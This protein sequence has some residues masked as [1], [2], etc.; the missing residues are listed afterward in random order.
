MTDEQRPTLRKAPDA[1]AHPTAGL[2]SEDTILRGSTSDAVIKDKLVTLEVEIP[3]S[4]RK[5]MRAEARQR[6]ITLDALVTEALRA[7]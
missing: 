2:A 7:R 1:L 4:L 3:K 5:T 6:G